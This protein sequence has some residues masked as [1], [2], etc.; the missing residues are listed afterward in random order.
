MLLKSGYIV[1]MN[2]K[3]MN[4]FKNYTKAYEFMEILQRQFPRAMIEIE[5]IY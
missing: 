5:P 4:T 2:S 3:Y 1:L